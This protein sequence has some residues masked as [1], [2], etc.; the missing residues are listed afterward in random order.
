MVM[1]GAH[2]D[3]WHT[4]TGAYRQCCRLL[5]DDGRKVHVQVPL[6]VQT[7][8]T[9]RIALWSGEEQG[10]LG[11]HGY[12]EKHFADINSMQQLEEYND[13]VYFNLDNGTGSIRGLYLEGNEKVSGRF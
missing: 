3:S 2:L 4:S 9:I 10:L 1:I 13:F 8:R 7:K 6:N 11:S 5:S 12:G